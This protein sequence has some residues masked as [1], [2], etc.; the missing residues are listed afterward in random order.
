MQTLNIEQQLRL[1][2]VDVNLGTSILKLREL[3]EETT[4][5][6]LRRRYRDAAVRLENLR[7]DLRL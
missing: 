6:H 4:D 7:S 3:A 2:I 1:S 5:G